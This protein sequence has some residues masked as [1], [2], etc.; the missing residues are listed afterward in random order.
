[1]RKP[2]WQQ[3]KSGQT[4]LRLYGKMDRVKT[5]RLA[6]ARL[7]RCLSAPEA[8]RL[9]CVSE[10]TWKGWELLTDNRRQPTGG[11]LVAI[12]RTFPA[13]KVEDLTTNPFCYVEPHTLKVI[14]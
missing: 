7:L 1:M 13:L 6:R 2:K 10:A 3:T 9:A 5:T 12:L 8:A 14:E 4:W 11:W